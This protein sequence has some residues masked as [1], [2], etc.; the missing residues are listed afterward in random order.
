MKS[1]RKKV[2]LKKWIFFFKLL[3]IIVPLVIWTTYRKNSKNPNNTLKRKQIKNI[4]KNKYH[5]FFKS[6]NF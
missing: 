4:K 6:E 2:N 5:F 3:V 1:P